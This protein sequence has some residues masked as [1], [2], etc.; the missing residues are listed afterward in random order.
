MSPWFVLQ[1]KPKS[2]RKVER[3]LIKKGYEC[4]APTYRSK[5]QWSDRIVEIDVPLFPGYVFCHLNKSEFREVLLTEGV[6]RM[7]KFGRKPA[8]VVIEEI[9]ALRLLAGSNLSQESW[10]YH[11]YGTLVLV[12]SG[13]LAGV[14]GIITT[15]EKRKQLILSVTSLQR[16][17]AVHLDESTIISVV[18]GEA[19]I[20]CES[21]PPT[22]ELL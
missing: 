18:G 15:N 3:L 9:E 7:V 5:R 4:F 22:D 17:I 20:N 16:S 10:H 6:I 13:P 19:R 8:E 12:K 1:T 2:E 21:L 11:P 14:Q